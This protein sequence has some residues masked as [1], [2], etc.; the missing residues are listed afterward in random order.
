M[1]TK[2]TFAL[3]LGCEK[4]LNILGDQPPG[5]ALLHITLFTVIFQLY[6]FLYKRCKTKQ[7][8]LDN[9]YIQNLRITLVEN[10]LNIYGLGALIAINILA[11]LFLLMEV[12]I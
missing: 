2:G 11:L 12:F 1:L 4:M 10:I 8:K 5:K 9:N 7:H 3:F 6:V